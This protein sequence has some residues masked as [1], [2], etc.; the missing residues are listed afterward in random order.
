MGRIPEATIQEIRDRADIVGLIGRHVELKQSGRSF[1]GICPF[2]DEKTPSF[3]VNPDRQMFHCFGCHEGGDVLS[4]LIKHENLTF[5]EAASTLARELGIEIPESESGERGET[6]RI[7]AALEAAQACYRQVLRGPLG[8][9]GRAYLERRGLGAEAIDRFGLGAVP[10]RWDTLTR[11]LESARIPG[12]I[13]VAAGLLC[14]RKSGGYYDRLRGRVTFPIN[15]VRGR[16]IAFGGRAV[17]PDQEPKYLNTSET[18]VFHKRLSFYGFPHALEPIRRAERA[19]LCEGYFDTIALHRAGISEALATCGTAL[20][21][22]HAKQLR[23]RTAQVSL[24]FD[25]DE[26]GLQAMERALAMLLP[27][28]LRVRAVRLPAGEDPDDYLASRGA[29]ALR[30]LVDAAPDALELV[31]RR[32][33]SVGC[34]TPGEKA[35]AVRRVA[36]LVAVIPNPVE[37]SEYGRRL[38]VATGTD[39]QAVEAVVRA[40]ARGQSLEASGTLATSVARPH[41]ASPEDR[42]MRLLI[43]LISRQP[44]DVTPELCERMR[45]ILPDGIWKDLVFHLI[46]AANEGYLAEDGS[47]D[48][49][50]MQT[51]L[52]PEELVA[53]R[54]VTVDESLLENGA[55]LLQMLGD[56]LGRYAAKHLDAQEMELKRRM[57]DPQEDPLALLRQRQALLERRRAAAGIG[58][59]TA[60]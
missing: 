16:V 24:V 60:P 59:E 29:E 58:L 51:R 6:E 50:L 48:I 30:S 35:D 10:D 32:A 3:H 4:F 57:Q 25:G 52:G 14:E 34:T 49:S 33:M 20:T 38:A 15:D 53:L 26:A 54:E 45:E 27:A 17:L 22:D 9:T 41:A 31:L 47:V 23:R 42:H 21:S 28:G 44:A 8:E 36:P 55:P 37:R 7:L 5:P 56:L 13:G 12:R 43:L 2:H 46:D 1:K 39:P 11:E 19:V 40:S 18:P